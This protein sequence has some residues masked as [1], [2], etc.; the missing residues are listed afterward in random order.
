MTSS[1]L[2]QVLE[3]LVI[4]K[5]PCKKIPLIH[6]I[7]N[8]INYL[9]LIC[10]SSLLT[11]NEKYIILKI[12]NTLDSVPVA[13]KGLWGIC[14]ASFIANAVLFFSPC[15]QI[16]QNIQLHMAHLFSF[17]TC[18]LLNN[19]RKHSEK[20]WKAP[21]HLSLWTALNYFP[22]IITAD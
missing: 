14:N 3:S 8:M 18:N 20:R 12:L 15:F 16:L 5:R 9:L 7:W 11:V 2:I 1:G 6:L 4:L 10:G 21:C 22:V 13:I 19:L 17:Y